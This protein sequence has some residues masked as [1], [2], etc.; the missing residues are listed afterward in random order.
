[1]IS[2]DHTIN[3]S[4]TNPVW[5]SDSNNLMGESGTLNNNHVELDSEGSA[6]FAGGSPD[7]SHHF[8]S[9]VSLEKLS[10][11]ILHGDDDTAARNLFN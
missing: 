7:P 11:R 1:M 5:N 3:K 6:F 9:P 2:H 8:S 4:S 10:M